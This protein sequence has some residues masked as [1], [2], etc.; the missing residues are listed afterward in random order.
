MIKNLENKILFAISE[1]E[2]E[3]KSVTVR[4]I[5]INLNM[6]NSLRSIYLKLKKMW[7]NLKEK[8]YI[9]IVENRIELKQTNKYYE[10]IEDLIITKNRNWE[11]EFLNELY[12]IIHIANW[13]CENKHEEWKKYINTKYKLWQDVILANKK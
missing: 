13:T 2:K 3:K 4:N 8:C 10:L 11:D 5:A 7:I 6:N 12:M 1:L 9:D